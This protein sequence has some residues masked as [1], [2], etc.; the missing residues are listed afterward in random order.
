MTSIPH[1]NSARWLLE[2]TAASASADPTAFQE[3]RHLLCSVAGFDPASRT[4]FV[5]IGVLDI[6]ALEIL[7]R[8]Y[9]AAQ[10]FGAEVRVQAIVA[11]DTW[12]G[13][14]FTDV[15]ELATLAAA[16]ADRSRPLGQLPV[17]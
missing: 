6:R 16:Q 10:R 1:P 13:P 8:L 11:P 4:W 5:R 17:S 3:Q 15:G 2:V 7:Q 14:C 9:E 12:K